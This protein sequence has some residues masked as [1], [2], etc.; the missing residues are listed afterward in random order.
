MIG[1]IVITIRQDNSEGSLIQSNTQTAPLQS[2]FFSIIILAC[3][4]FFSKVTSNI[5]SI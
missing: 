5:K 3:N 4:N 2:N 1:A